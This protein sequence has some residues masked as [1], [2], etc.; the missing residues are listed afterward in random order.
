MN[1]MKETIRALENSPEHIATLC[2]EL[3]PDAWDWKPMSWEA[4]PGEMFSFREHVCHLLDFDHLVY[5]PR[6]RRARDEAQPTFPR[7]FGYEL[8]EQRRYSEIDPIKTIAEFDAAR[9]KTVATI[10]ALDDRELRRTADLAQYGVI[11][12][13]GII[14]LLYDHDLRHMACMHWLLAK[15]ACDIQV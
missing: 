5:H 13:S 12:V 6:I 7:V 15:R 10:V 8:A 9:K 4:C 2:K 3:S 1:I 14:H 11:T